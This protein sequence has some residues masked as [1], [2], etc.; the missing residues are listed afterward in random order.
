MLEELLLI[1]YLQGLLTHPSPLASDACHTQQ[2]RF[3]SNEHSSL[4]RG[5]L[6]NLAVVRSTSGLFL[7]L[8]NA[9]SNPQTTSSI[10]RGVKLG[11][12][13]VWHPFDLMGLLSVVKLDDLL[14]KLV[15]PPLGNQ[16][17]PEPVVSSASNETNRKG[18]ST[19]LICRVSAGTM[20][21]LT[22]QHQSQHKCRTRSLRRRHI[23]LPP[24]GTTA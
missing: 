16:L 1:H 20:F 4:R 17:G 9:G 5:G 12:L 13:L 2:N 18:Q 21:A 8:K 22:F 14:S 7:L 6:S 15:S 11:Q 19:N 3:G 10:V 24:E 23:G